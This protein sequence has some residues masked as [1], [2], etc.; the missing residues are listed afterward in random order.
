MNWQWAVLGHPIAH[1]L[2]PQIHQ[3]F[4][5]Q[6]GL[7]VQ[8]DAIDVAPDAFA[9]HLEALIAAGY[10]GFNVTVPH[11]EHASQWAQH[12]SG[13]ASRATSV[14]VL[15]Q[16]SERAGD[17]TG[18]TTDGSGLLYDLT[19]LQG[20]TLQG[21][22]ILLLGAGG[23]ARGVMEALLHSYPE[24]LAV[25]NRTPARAEALCEQFTIM[26]Q[27]CSVALMA[28]DAEQLAAPWD[29]VIN[30]TAASLQ[31]ELPQVPAAAI[32]RASACYDM[33]YGA[34]PT[35]FLNWAQE[36]G[37]VQRCDGLGMLVGQA[38]ESFYLWTGQ[39]PSC[40]PILAAIRQT[41]S[42]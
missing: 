24:T 28:L 10:N 31:G 39:R 4:A 13:R 14:N 21:Q 9:E 37:V 11:K 33:V 17:W 30:A 32:A 3:G 7:Q 12:L 38:A 29:L 16:D 18:D 27:Q 6:L 40:E 36:L 19:K 1:S 34:Q 22:R 2:S 23:A 5:Q 41:L 20:L 25:W 35:T 15:F 26:A 42:R 8:Y